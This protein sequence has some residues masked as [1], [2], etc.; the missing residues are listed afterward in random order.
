MFIPMLRTHRTAV[1]DRLLL[2]CAVHGV[3]VRELAAIA[4]VAPDHLIAVAA[5][6]AQLGTDAAPVAA[7]V[8]CAAAWLSD[9]AGSPPAW[10]V[11]SAGRAP[12]AQCII[13]RGRR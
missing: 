13:K 8:G 5:G 12:Q 10:A 9:G 1:A 4:S 7:A 2:A 3:T 6:R 11:P